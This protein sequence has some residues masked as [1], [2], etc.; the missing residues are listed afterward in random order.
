M[1]FVKNLLPEKLKITLKNIGNFFIPGENI[2]ESKNKWNKLASKNSRYFVMTD[3]GEGITE[4]EFRETGEKDFKELVWDDDFIK[5]RLGDF[6]E[7]IA[8]EIGCGTGRI[9]EFLSR[10]FKKV[11]AVDISEKMIEEGRQRLKDATNIEFAAINGMQY[12]TIDDSSIDFVFS[13]IVFQHMPNKKVIKKNFEE[14]KRVLKNDG[15]AKIQ[16]RGLPTNKFNWFYGP[17]FTQKEVEKLTAETGMKLL[18]T[19]GE[20]KRY[21][22]LWL[23]K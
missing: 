16:V 21:F 20:N 4:T 23:S 9:T 5:D 13:Y 8:L 10:Y 15:I 6:K 1:K 11:F 7:K 18:K 3:L 17:S 2:A 22:W 12:P 14:I 19:D